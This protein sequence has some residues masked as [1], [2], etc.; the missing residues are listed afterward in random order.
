MAGALPSS[1]DLPPPGRI[2]KLLALREGI[3]F[4]G[5]R[6]LWSEIP[7]K[8]FG[9]SRKHDRDDEIAHAASGEPQ[10][11]DSGVVNVAVLLDEIL[12]V[13]L[14]VDDRA[15]GRP[16]GSGCEHKV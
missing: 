10:E 7:P 14:H 1:P 12:F 5:A 11:L 4:G 6:H 9:D 15:V 3:H 2:S 13:F 8:F 16:H